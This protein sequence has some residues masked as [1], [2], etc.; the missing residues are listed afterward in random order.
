MSRP[1]RHV[2]IV[3]YFGHYEVAEGMAGA[4]DRSGVRVSLLVDAAFTATLLGPEWR[5]N[6]RFYAHP[7]P[8]LWTALSEQQPLLASADLIV[9]TTIA[10]QWRR[11]ATYPYLSKS[12]WVMHNLHNLLG[13]RIAWGAKAWYRYWRYAGPAARR[14]AAH[15]GYLTFPN[16]AMRAYAIDRLGSPPA[17][18]FPV[19]PLVG[20]PTHPPASLGEGGALRIVV[21]GTVDSEL[22]DVGPLLGAV[23]RLASAGTKVDLVFAGRNKLSGLE[24]RLASLPAGVSYRMY[25]RTLDRGEYYEQ[26]RRGHVWVLPVR[27]RPLVRWCREEWGRS[28][29][30]GVW[31]DWLREGRPLLA[32]TA[33]HLPPELA[34]IIP[35]YSGA[36]ELFRHLVALTEAHYR[37]EW[38]ERAYIARVTYL[39]QEWDQFRLHWEKWQL[40]PP[41][42]FAHE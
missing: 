39:R 40:R 9:F 1:I 29:V 14:L 3:E 25:Q 34:T 23:R 15:I 42:T 5:N 22:R 41:S 19:P 33:Y 8:D 12:V 16:R 36:A 28:K 26:L 21:P 20:V 7:A 18:L 35:S 32:S 17:R 30:S 31:Q 2:C 37:E 24:K 11:L 38:M 27:S 4:L 13:S 10:G 6:R